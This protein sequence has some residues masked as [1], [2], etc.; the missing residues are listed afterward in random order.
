VKTFLTSSIF[1]VANSHFIKAQQDLSNKTYAQFSVWQ[2]KNGNVVKPVPE[3][4][5][6]FNLAAVVTP[7]I[8]TAV[9]LQK[10]PG[11]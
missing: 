4:M 5:S 3:K 10:K 1:F 2:A 9:S 6:P 11:A 7:D 8:T